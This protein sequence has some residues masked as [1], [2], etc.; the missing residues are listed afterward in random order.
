[1]V[2]A[3]ANEPKGTKAVCV[4]T[5]N[6]HVTEVAFPKAVLDSTQG[7]DWTHVRVNVAIDDRD[8]DGGSQ[9]WW[10]PDWRTTSLPGTGTFVKAGVQRKR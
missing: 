5:K 8:S 6:G 3:R 9:L 4:K 1:M 7:T 10:Y 2:W